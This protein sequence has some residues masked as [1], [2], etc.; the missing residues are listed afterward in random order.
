MFLTMGKTIGYVRVSAVDDEPGR[1]IAALDGAECTQIFRD[2][3][4]GPVEPRPALDQAL[5]AL[6]PGDTL[7]IWSL[8]RAARSIRDT[9]DLVGTLIERG[10]HLRVLA[11]GID[12][13][14]PGDAYLVF[15]ALSGMER[16]VIRERTAAR[17]AEARA[18]G[19]SGGRPPLLTAD[20]IAK[21]RELYARG[22]MTVAEIGNSLG[23]SRTTI[24]RAL[25]Q[26]GASAVPPRRPPR[27]VASL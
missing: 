2:H 17:L 18:R 8:D 1:Q 13:S 23:V 10:V 6:S 22:G 21:A 20:Q 27:R 15:T 16:D 7:V 3:T 12:T 5:A 25:E 19:R 14:T 9:L 26:E 24:Y 4:T 11:S